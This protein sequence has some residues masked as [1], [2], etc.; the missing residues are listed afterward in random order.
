MTS[1]QKLFRKRSISSASVGISNV[2]PIGDHSS[3][4][5]LCYDRRL[6]L[7][8]YKCFYCFRSNGFSF[9]FY[10]QY[11]WGWDGRQSYRI[12]IIIIFLEGGNKIDES[13]IWYSS[14]G[15]EIGTMSIFRKNGPPSKSLSQKAVHGSTRAFSL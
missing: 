3:I 6:R 4:C 1:V 10:R 11:D 13:F 8:R 5:R 2:F 15:L 12:A 14:A 7:L 9:P